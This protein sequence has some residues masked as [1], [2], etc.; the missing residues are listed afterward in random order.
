MEKRIKI[1]FPLYKFEL[2][3]V[4]NNSKTAK[5]IYDILPQQSNIQTWAE[6]IYFHLPLDLPNEN[7]TLDVNIGDVGW[8]PEGNCLC[9]FFGKTPISDSEKPKP[10]SEV[11]LIGRIDITKDIFLKLKSDSKVILEKYEK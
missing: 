2:I 11:T 5:K 8:W 1:S 10:Y 3:C 9:I 4:L 6:E 7:P